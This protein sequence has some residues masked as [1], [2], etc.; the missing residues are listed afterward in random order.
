MANVNLNTRLI[1]RNDVE[2]AWQSANPQ[3]LKGEFAVSTDAAGGPKIKVGDGTKTWSE[4]SYINATPAELA[5]YGVKSV[6]IKGSGNG[7]A[8][9]SFSDGVLT[10]TKG[11]FLTEHQDI[12]GKLDKNPDVSPV[13]TESFV[14]VKYDAKG[15]ITGSTPVVKGDITGLGIPAQDT[16][17]TYTL[18]GETNTTT[19]ANVVL[20]PSEGGAQKLNIVGG[21][22]TSVAYAD[23]KIT[24]T[25]TDTSKSYNFF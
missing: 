16:N 25:S 6:S 12:S 21:G 2:S 11:T 15:L 24:I 3:L 20:T 14:K 23:G 5:A 22:T 19:G 1:I 4:L 17:T 18:S 8:N 9:A 10:L 7:I 13:A